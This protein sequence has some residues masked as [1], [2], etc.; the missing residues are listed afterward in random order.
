[1]STV[2]VPHVDTMALRRLAEASVPCKPELI[3]SNGEPQPS[4]SVRQ[5]LHELQVHQIELEMQ[6]EQL[7]HTQ[8]ELDGARARYF[9]LFD[10]APIGYCTVNEQGLILEANFTAATMLNLSRNELVKQNVSRFI[11]RTDQ[12]IYYQCRQALL[13]T[14]LTQECELQMLRR[15]G[16][17][18]WVHLKTSAA[19]DALGAQIQRMTW[20]DI[21]TRK[22]NEALLLDKARELAVAHAV[23]ERARQAKSDFLMNMT[24]E[25]RSPLNSILG[26]AQL[27][28]MSTPAPTLKQKSNIDQIQRAGWHLLDLVGEILDLTAIESGELALSLVPVALADVLQ[29]CHTLVEARALKTGI[30]LQFVPL[31]QAYC[32]NADRSRLKQVLVH[33]LTNAIQYNRPGGS[34]ELSCSLVN[35]QRLRISVRDTGEGL[36][37]EKLAQL[38]QPFNR[39]GRETRA[40]AGTGIGLAVS[41]RLVEL[42]G[43]NI[44]AL[45]TEGL[46]CVFWIELNL[47][48]EIP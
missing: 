1:M 16:P 15:D 47:Q 19:H 4:E 44:G 32:V 7:R 34:V 33:L 29:E 18:T 2:N 25:L 22:H 26:F 20:T 14:G 42:M 31:A 6:N 11:V 5:L 3:A 9:D 43:A 10:L 39:L 30:S 12:D 36:S 48:R 28:E 35:G 40:D 21:S 8:Q 38:F 23:A 37:N 45:S 41:K 17:A 27:L 46:G 13:S 24:H